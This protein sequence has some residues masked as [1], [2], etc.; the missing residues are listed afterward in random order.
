MN[1]LKLHIGASAIDDL[2]KNGWIPK[3]IPVTFQQYVK[4]VLA[5]VMFDNTAAVSLLVTQWDPAAGVS[6]LGFAENDWEKIPMSWRVPV[7]VGGNVYPSKYAYVFG[8]LE[9]FFNTHLRQYGVG[10]MFHLLQEQ[11]G[12]KAE[13]IGYMGMRAVAVIEMP[14]QQ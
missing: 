13:S 2:A 10:M 3:E 12:S 1:N 8:M 7:Q 11:S 6:G 4:G 9:G 14:P 5:Q